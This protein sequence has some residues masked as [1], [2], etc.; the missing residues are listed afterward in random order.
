[1]ACPPGAHVAEPHAPLLLLSLAAGAPIL[2]GARDPHD[3][4]VLQ[5]LD[6]GFASV[7]GSLG[8]VALHPTPVLARTSLAGSHALWQTYHERNFH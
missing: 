4:P 7:L 3:V 2:F 8:V 1:M 6:L 5:P